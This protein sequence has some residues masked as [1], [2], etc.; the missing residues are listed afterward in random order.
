MT[1]RCGSAAAGF[2]SRFTTPSSRDLANSADG[3]VSPVTHLSGNALRW[4]T[5]RPVPLWP[6]GRLAASSRHLVMPSAQTSV[7]ASGSV[8]Q[9]V[10]SIVGRN[11]SGGRC[12]VRGGAV[13]AWHPPMAKYAT[14]DGIGQSV[15]SGRSSFT[16]L[17]CRPRLSECRNQGS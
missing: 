3:W 6:D 17:R 4:H 7:P 10:S 9:K 12:P 2:G 14:C 1:T 11:G 8:T 5:C 15:A 13:A 16:H